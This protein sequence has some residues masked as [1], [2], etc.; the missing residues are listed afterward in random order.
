MSRI[1][2]YTRQIQVSF[3]GKL[4]SYEICLSVTGEQQ[5][6]FHTLTVILL[7]MKMLLI[8]WNQMRMMVLS[9][10]GSLISEVVLWSI[11]AQMGHKLHKG[12]KLSSIGLTSLALD[13]NILQQKTCKLPHT[14]IHHKAPEF[15]DLLK[16]MFWE[17]I[18]HQSLWSNT[19]RS[20]LTG[21]LPG[22]CYAVARLLLVHWSK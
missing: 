13:Q 2:V 19:W 9:Q 7:Q 21:E 17:K 3:T 22:H 1:Y 16:E 18:N 5:N 12:Q 14:W 10:G 15:R 8:F 4:I 20:D 11:C 6:T